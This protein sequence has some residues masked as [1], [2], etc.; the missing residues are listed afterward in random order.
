MFP[1]LLITIVVLA[2]QTLGLQPHQYSP[3]H[4][5]S[6]QDLDLP[7]GNRMVSSP[8]NPL[9]PTCP[10]QGDGMDK[11]SGKIA[12]DQPQNL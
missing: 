5:T 10:S 4:L 3:K 1:F 2:M 6:D 12:A 8:H 7:Y 9:L 11:N